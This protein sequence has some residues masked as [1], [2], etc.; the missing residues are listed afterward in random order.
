[1]EKKIRD[2]RDMIERKQA[3]ITFARPCDRE[4]LLDELADLEV[5][6]RLLEITKA[7]SG[8]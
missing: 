8:Q 7:N 4:T 2:L 6:L 1:M 5:T 3:F